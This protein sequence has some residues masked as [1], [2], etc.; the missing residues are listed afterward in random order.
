MSVLRCRP[1]CPPMCSGLI[2]VL[3][4]RD[5]KDA[6]AMSKLVAKGCSVLLVQSFSLDGLTIHVSASSHLPC[7][8]SL[9]QISCTSHLSASLA[10][11]PSCLVT[12]ALTLGCRCNW[13]LGVGWHLQSEMCYMR[14]RLRHLSPEMMH[15]VLGSVIHNGL[16]VSLVNVL[17]G[18]QASCRLALVSPK[19]E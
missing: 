16:Q 17:P 3:F 1:F 12:I 19:H 10:P 11:G 6:S 7:L 9:S 13:P 15:C 2:I 8:P 18:R 14:C 4:T 5:L